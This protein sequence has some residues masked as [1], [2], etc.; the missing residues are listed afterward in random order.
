M[1]KIDRAWGY[2]CKI[3]ESENHFNDLVFRIR[4]LSSTWLLASFAGIGFILTRD[5]DIGVTKPL[6][7]LGI[8]ILAAF[9]LILLWMMDILVYQNLLA[10]NFEEGLNIE[11]DFPDLPQIRHKMVAS[12]PKGSVRTRIVWFHIA[13]IVGALTPGFVICI[14]WLLNVRP[15]LVVLMILIFVVMT[16]GIGAF[17]YFKSIPDDRKDGNRRSTVV[18]SRS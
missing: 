12:Q 4:A 8:S 1:E 5:F 9:G 14:F 6:L 15:N 16:I 18:G 13:M 17:I 11:N 7:T 2:L 3:T 10:A